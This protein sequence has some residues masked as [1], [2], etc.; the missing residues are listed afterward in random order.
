M[1]RLGTGNTE[2]FQEDNTLWQIVSCSESHLCL[3]LIC[4]LTGNGKIKRKEIRSAQSSDDIDSFAF[5]YS[6]AIQAK[7]TKWHIMK[8]IGAED[9]LNGWVQTFLE[10][11]SNLY[12]SRSLT[13][14]WNSIE[15]KFLYMILK[16]E[17]I[18]KNLTSV[19]YWHKLRRSCNIFSAI[20]SDQRKKKH[21]SLATYTL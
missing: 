4:A 18:L 8:N 3:G 1:F 20:H 13:R 14:P 11:S 9:I 7:S 2:K 12:E 19:W 21:I 15:M 10:S 17:V 5:S 6:A 16:G